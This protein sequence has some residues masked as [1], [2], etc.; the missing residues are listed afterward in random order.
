MHCIVA[1][2]F[3][4]QRA[5]TFIAKLLLS[6]FVQL[7][8]FHYQVRIPLACIILLDSPNH[9]QPQFVANERICVHMS[10]YMCTYKHMRVHVCIYVYVRNCTFTYI[11]THLK[12]IAAFIVIRPHLAAIPLFQL[13]LRLIPLNSY[14]RV[15]TV[16]I[17]YY[18]YCI[19]S[20]SA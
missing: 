9:L 8:W 18:Q 13:F 7:F 2:S 3:S 16:P 20:I 10:P 6:P 1:D 15:K 12:A 4:F 5:T 17:Q 11:I 19:S 14:I